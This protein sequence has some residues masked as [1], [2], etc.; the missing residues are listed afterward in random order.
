VTHADGTTIRIVHMGDSITAGQYVDPRLRWTSL[1]MDRLERE[2][3]DDGVRVESVNRGVSGETTRQGLERFPADVQR[4]RP[5]IVTLQFGLNDC[6]CWQTDLGL[7]RVSPAAF[8]ANLVEMIAR[9]RRFGAAH[10][11]LANNHPT[12]RATT[13]P[14]GER[15]EDANAR[16]SAIV[17][18]V[19]R[20]TGVTFCDIR[21]GFE[22]YSPAELET[23]L[24][25][26]PDQL[27][28]SVEG[29]RV[30]AD[31]IW[32]LVHGAVCERRAALTRTGARS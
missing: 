23:L 6:N 5:D 25:P 7:P 14:G 12:L 18:E 29:N 11:I 16:Y 32:P 31:A 1:L 10:V 26:Y 30:Y 3:V 9:A 4:E 24:L 8:H 27:H 13:M 15:Y 17:Q 19:A 21:L 22:R 2:R 20:E 28:L